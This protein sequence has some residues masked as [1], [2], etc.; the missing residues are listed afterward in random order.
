M[1]GVKGEK[2]EARGSL[3]TFPL[4]QSTAQLALLPALRKGWEGNLD[5]RPALPRA[6]LAPLTRPKSPFRSF[7]APP[8]QANFLAVSPLFCL[9]LWTL[10]TGY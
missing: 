10:V 5:T 7:Q 3:K 1:G 6:R 9:L 4:L 8:T 2:K